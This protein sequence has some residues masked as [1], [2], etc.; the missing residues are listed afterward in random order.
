MPINV[1]LSIGINVFTFFL[2]IYI[3]IF[4]LNYREEAMKDIFIDVD[5]FLRITKIKWFD[6]NEAIL[7]DSK[8][9]GVSL[10]KRKR[11]G[12]KLLMKLSDVVFFIKCID[13]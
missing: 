3:F 13:S 6:Y 7:N 2:I 10:P 5:S 1:D 4:K 11:I 12:N 9:N 8:Y